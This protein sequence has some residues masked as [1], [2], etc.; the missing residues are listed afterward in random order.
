MIRHSSSHVIAADFEYVRGMVERNYIGE[1]PLC[2][3]LRQLLTA[4][5]ECSEAILTDSGTAAL[6][7]ALLGL[8]QQCAGRS[9]VLLSAY[10]CP[11]VLSAV[12]RAGLEPVLVDTRADS[13]NM[14]MR[15][16]RSRIDS[17]TLAVICSHIGGIPDDCATA[18]TLGVPVI[19][20][21]AQAVGSR[22][23]GRDV[24]CEGLCAILSFGA[25]KMVTA[26]GGGALLCRD[27]SLAAAVAQ[28]A[29]PELPAAEYRRVGFRVTYGQHMGDLTAGLASAQLRRLGATV[30]RRR[31]I[32][33]AYERALCGRADAQP[34]S[35]PAGVRANRFRYYFLS[36]QAHRWI[37]SLHS[38][39][40][41]ARG[42]IS[43]A[44]PEY[45]TGLGA[46]PG[47]ADVAS[48]VV[49]VPI[50]PGMTDG[51]V[52]GVVTALQRGPGGAT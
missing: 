49:S 11:Q 25:T 6:H 41:D 9:T 29:R 14:D 5:F 20:D 43:H 44:I 13:L 26:G 52:S 38:Q 10:V 18:A 33:E 42:S 4:Q 21:C 12:I 8:A 35:E 36:R 51:E 39:G 50:F 40:I 47:L 7:L 22:A 27:E 34:V 48:M 17:R 16:A 24:A 19:S 45:G 32:A 30:A 15:A 46:F 31:G 2:D 37:A 3:E 23:Q 28:L 1:G